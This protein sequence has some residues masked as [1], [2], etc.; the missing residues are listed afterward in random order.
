MNPQIIVLTSMDGVPEYGEDSAEGFVPESAFP[1]IALGGRRG[2]VLD[3]VAGTF[4]NTGTTVLDLANAHG[5]V[6]VVVLV[7]P[8]EGDWIKAARI[9][10]PILVVERGTPTMDDVVFRLLRGADAV[11]GTGAGLIELLETAARVAVGEITVSGDVARGVLAAARRSR[12]SAVTLTPVELA[13]L[14]SAARGATTKQAAARLG[15]RTSAAEHVMARLVRK[16][17]VRNR[18][19]AIAHAYRLGLLTETDR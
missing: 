7:E 3:V 6:A 10:A 13:V 5:D 16:L 18:S 8:S 9:T 12:A 2:F 19:Q 11:V 4:Q 17:G 1:K 14:S 15:M